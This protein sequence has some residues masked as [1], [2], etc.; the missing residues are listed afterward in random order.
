M[1]LEHR[2]TIA[3]SWSTSDVREARKQLDVLTDFTGTALNGNLMGRPNSRCA[4]LS[5]HGPSVD[6][7]ARKTIAAS[8]GKALHIVRMHSEP[9]GPRNTI[10]RITA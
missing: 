2:E 8:V 10:R 5:L 1:N 3:Y 4:I 9:Q 7:I 6:G